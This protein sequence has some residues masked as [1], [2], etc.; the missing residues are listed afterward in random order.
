LTLEGVRLLQIQ[1]TQLILLRPKPSAILRYLVAR[2]GQ[3][4]TKAELL[5]AVWLA[6]VVS[7]ELLNTYIRDLRKVLEDDPARRDLLKP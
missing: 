1:G 5:K 3:L 2:P 7:E 6:A 4:V